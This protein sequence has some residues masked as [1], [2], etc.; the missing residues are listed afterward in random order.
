MN[1]WAAKCCLFGTT[2]DSQCSTED[3]LKICEIPILEM[4]FL[5][6]SSYSYLSLTDLLSHDHHCVLSSFVLQ[7]Q[8]INLITV[9]TECWV[10]FSANSL[11][12]LP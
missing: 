9:M 7:K 10:F 4:V 11:I 5:F 12:H 2:Q 6:A 3:G 1:V 8:I